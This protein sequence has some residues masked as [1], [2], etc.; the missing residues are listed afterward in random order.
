VA[1]DDSC[2]PTRAD[3][4]LTI[5]SEPTTPKTDRMSDVFADIVKSA[6]KDDSFSPTRATE[7]VTIA[8]KI[9]LGQ[10]LAI[11]KAEKEAN[12]AAAPKMTLGQA[13]AKAKAEKEANQAA[14]PKM[15]LGQALAKAKAEKEASGAI[16]RLE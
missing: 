4:V 10:A 14:A 12:Q 15:T 7:V 9:S 16:Q 8:P 1:K 2:N 5:V 3:E 13:L 11:A 6:T